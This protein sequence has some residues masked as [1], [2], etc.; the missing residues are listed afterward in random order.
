MAAEKKYISEYCFSIL[1]TDNW[2][3]GSQSSKPYQGKLTISP[4]Y[5]IENLGVL[6]GVEGD[7]VDGFQS[8]ASVNNFECTQK[9]VADDLSMFFDEALQ[10]GLKI[11][12]WFKTASSETQ[13]GKGYITEITISAKDKGAFPEMK[14]KGWIAKTGNMAKPTIASATGKPLKFTDINVAGLKTYTLELTMNN[15]K[16]PLWVLESGYTDNFP[17]DVMP[18]ERTGSV[19]FMVDTDNFRTYNDLY[20]TA[21]PK[22]IT[23]AVVNIGSSNTITLT[24]VAIDSG[25]DRD[26]EATK[27]LQLFDISGT[28]CNDGTT[29]CFVY[30]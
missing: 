5:K 16:E 21:E 13:M 18:I 20:A 14:I 30:A 28:L 9:I 26:I 2:D 4:D 23:S 25:V 22:I 15:G 3:T 29:V 1:A 11:G 10:Q 19:K 27:D 24:K 17:N 8:A 6:I 7:N 12:L